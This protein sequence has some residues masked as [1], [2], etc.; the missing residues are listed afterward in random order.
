MKKCKQILAKSIEDIL[1]YDQNNAVE[2][3]VKTVFETILMSERTDFLCQNSNDLNKG[4]GYYPRLARCI[5][6]YFELKIPRDRLSLFKPVFLEAI[7]KQEDLMQDLAFK[8]YTK[9]LTT[10]DVGDIFGEVYG[11]SLSPTSVSNITKEF[12][13]QRIAWQ[14]KSVND[15]YYFIYVDALYIPVRRDT[16]EKEAFYIVIGLRPDLKR[17]ILGVYNMPT[18]SASGW[19][20]VFQDL[21]ARGLKSCLMVIADGLKNMESIVKMEL[22]MAKMQKCLV[23][24]IRNIINHARSKD[25]AQLSSDFNDVFQLENPNYSFEDGVQNLN[26]FINKWAKRYP[27]IRA[28]FEHNHLEHYFAYLHFPYP[29]HRMIYTTNWI[30]RLN[31]SIRKT[32]NVRNSFPNQDSAMNLICAHLIDFER[33]VYKYPVTAFMKVKDTLDAM[34]FTCHQ[35]QLS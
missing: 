2:L 5:N 20:E 13:E 11:K 12:E 26:E 7:K 35:T 15:C 22:P 4:N 17:D 18:E 19:A 10:R 8:L 24:K 34:L 1:Y 30:E 9:G 27:S 28:K 23:H 21:K 32:T 31:K 6:Q 3:V 29:I 25:K 16:V 14:K 33:R